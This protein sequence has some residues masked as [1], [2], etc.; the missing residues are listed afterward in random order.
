MCCD[1]DSLDR[2][3]LAF[4]VGCQQPGNMQQQPQ[5]VR[6]NRLAAASQQI[7]A[8][9]SDRSKVSLFWSLQVSLSVILALGSMYGAE[10]FAGCLT[11]ALMMLVVCV[12]PFRSLPCSASAPCC[13]SMVAGWSHIPCV[14]H[15]AGCSGMSKSQ[16]LLACMACST[17]QSSPQPASPPPLPLVRAS[18][19]AGRHVRVACDWAPILKSMFHAHL[20]Q[21]EAS[22]FG[23]SS[24]EPT[25][26]KIITSSPAEMRLNLLRR[27]SLIWH[28]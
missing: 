25:T 18:R 9:V 20:S 21:P 17:T 4:V 12:S 16:V 8:L 7:I 14:P 26:K 28:T 15:M 5:L 2:A 1:V 23:T 19:W 10:V 3:T 27:S 6:F 22:A 13:S 11:A 24:F